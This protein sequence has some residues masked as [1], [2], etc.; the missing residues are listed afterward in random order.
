MTSPGYLAKKTFWDALKGAGWHAE[1][2]YRNYTVAELRDALEAAEL[3]IPEVPLP[4]PP[5]PKG[6]AARKSAPAK[7]PDNPQRINEEAAQPPRQKVVDT[8]ANVLRV[9]E[10]GRQWLQEEVRKPSYPKPRGRRVLKYLDTGT[11][12]E[13]VQNGEYIETFEVEGERASRPAEVKITMPSYQ[14]GIYRDPRFPFNIHCYN[15]NEAFDMFDVDNFF[16]G[17]ELVPWGVKRVYVENSLCYDIRSVVQAIQS[18]YRQLQ[19]S[20]RA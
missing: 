4:A 17:A 5:A 15:D 16:G 19:L 2:H 6:P 8:L 1:Q 10:Q 12:T 3:P 9:D 11:K 13:T 18:E 14:V 20:G 7:V